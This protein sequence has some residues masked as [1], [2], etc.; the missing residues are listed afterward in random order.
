ML[1]Q[2]LS[3]GGF[4]SSQNRPEVFMIDNCDK[5]LSLCTYLIFPKKFGDG[6]IKHSIKFLNIIGHRS[7]DC[8]ET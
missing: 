6:C 1:K 4:C 7:R 3:D 8:L 5:I 2:V